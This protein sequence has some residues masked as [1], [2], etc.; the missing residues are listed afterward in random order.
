M[1]ERAAVTCTDFLARMTDYFDNEVDASLLEEIRAHLA[2]CDH[3]EILVNTTRQTIQIYR[4]HQ[5]YEI[6]TE[7]REHLVSNIMHRCGLRH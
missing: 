6:S 7:V 2:E 5:V 1:L 4:D 3:C